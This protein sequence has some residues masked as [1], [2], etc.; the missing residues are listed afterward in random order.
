MWAVLRDDRL[1]MS[2]NPRPAQQFKHTT[3]CVLPRE[4]GNP[5]EKEYTINTNNQHNKTKTTKENNNT[6]KTN[7]QKQ[8]STGPVAYLTIVVGIF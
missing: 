1:S 6:L 5:A 7:Q 4:W 2:S 3:G 8:N